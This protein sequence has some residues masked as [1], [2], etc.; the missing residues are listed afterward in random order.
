MSPL[1]LPIPPSRRK[2]Q[3][4]FTEQI[5]YRQEEKIHSVNFFGRLAA[6]AAHQINDINTYDDAD[7]GIKD[8]VYRHWGLLHALR[9]TSGTPLSRRKKKS[10]DFPAACRQEKAARSQRE[11]RLFSRA[12]PLEHFSLKRCVVKTIWPVVSREKRG[13][14][15]QFGPGSAAASRFTFFKGETLWGLLTQN[16]QIISIC[17]TNRLCTRHLSFVVGRLVFLTFPR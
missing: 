1:R 4:Q 11:H 6:L 10:A 5:L 17:R 15:A 7:P 9:R 14:A 16:L 2:Q 13:F 3:R 12:R 8:T